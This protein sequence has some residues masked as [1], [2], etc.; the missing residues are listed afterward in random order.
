MQDEFPNILVISG[1]V[2]AR[3]ANTRASRDVFDGASDAS[4]ISFQSRWDQW[5]PTW[6]FFVLRLH[7]IGAGHIARDRNNRFHDAAADRCHLPFVPWRSYHHF[8]F[9]A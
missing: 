6:K 5:H 7:C 4:W 1:Y 8:E 2:V 3:S 9:S